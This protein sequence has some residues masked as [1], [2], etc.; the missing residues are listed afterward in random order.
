MKNRLLITFMGLSCFLISTIAANANSLISL[1]EIQ[2]AWGKE[3]RNEKQMLLIVNDYFSISSYNLIEKKFIHTWG[4]TIQKE[5]DEYKI[6]QEWNSIDSTQIGS[7]QSILVQIKKNKL[8]FGKITDLNKLEDVSIGP[9]LG[10]WIISGNYTNDVVSK[11]ANP[12][13]PRRTM[14]ILSGKYFQWI[15][16]NVQS[17]KFFDTGGGM[18]QAE[19]GKYT[20]QVQFFTKAVS[21]IGKE[22][23]FTYSINNGDWRHKGKKSTGGD[24]DECWTERKIIEG[25]FSK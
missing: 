16:Y 1:S 17:K 20:E 11:R 6:L 24:L 3:D 22:L 4:G 14:K 23:A 2:G 12:F 18:Y 8:S 9:L 5:G 10:V 13:Y 21:S 15:S 19:N 7:N 25:L